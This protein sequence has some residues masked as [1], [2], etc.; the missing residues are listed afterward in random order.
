M[1]SSKKESRTKI[2][3]KF[4]EPPENMKEKKRAKAPEQ[5]TPPIQE[6]PEPVSNVL[7]GDDILALAIKKEDLK[8]QHSPRLPETE[9]KPF[10]SQK[11]IIRKP[12]PKDT[13]RKICHLVAHPA[14]PEV[15]TKPLDYSGP[16]DHFDGSDQILP[17]HILGSLEDF[18]RIAIARGNTQLA[19]LIHIPPS[20]MTLISAK[21]EP[22]QKDLK[23]EKRHPWVPPPQ[24]NFLKNW[25]RHITLRKKQQEA[26]SEHLKKPVS[27]LLMHSGDT[28]RQIQE[29]R[30]LIDRILPTQHDGKSYKDTSVFWSPLEYLGDEMTGLV[31]TKTK[32]QHGFVEPI[33]RIRKPRSIQV[34]TGLPAQKDAWYRYTWDRSLFLIYR[35][36]ELQSI[37]AELDFSQQDID[38]LEVVGRGQP[39]SSVTVED[40]TVFER[41]LESPPE[42][43]VRLDLVDNCPDSVSMPVLGPSLLFCGKPA[44]WIRGSNPQDK[45]QIGIGV[46]LTF[47]TLEGEKTSSELTVVNN[48]TVAIWYDWRRLPQLDSF[49]HLKRDRMQQFY[50]NIREGV[51]LPGETKN[52]TFFFKS[53]SAGIFR[54]CWEFKTHPTLLGGALLQVNLHAVSLAQDIFKDERKFL[55]S[56][57]ATHDAVSIAKDVLQE[58]LRGILT[59]ERMPSPVDAYLTE[60]ELFCHRN[61]HLY[62]Q[63]HVVQNL[64]QLWNQCRILSAKS[65]EARAG[66]EEHL[67]PR[68]PVTPSAHLEKESSNVDNMTN[69]RNPVREPQPSQ[70]ENEAHSNFRDYST[71]QKTRVG[72]KISQRKS[73]MEE[74][75]VEIPEVD[76]TWSL[77]ELP[78]VPLTEWNLCLKEFRKAVMKLPEDHQKEDALISLNKAALELCQEQK[79]LQ[80]NLLHQLC[81]QLWRDVIDSLVSHSLWLRILLGL[82]EKE[83][84][85]L[86]VPEEQDRKSPPITEVKTTAGKIGKETEGRKGAMQEKKQL[87]IRD[88]EDK[89][90]ARMA[91]KEDRINSKKQKAKD[92]KKI[93]KSSSRDRLSS[94]DPAPDSTV[95]SHEPI[96]PLV[97]EKYMRRMHTE[98]LELLNVLVTDLMILA[99][100]LSPIKNVEESFHL[101]S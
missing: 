64:H 50:F 101:C 21:E 23:E 69:F 35:R 17:H 16:G 29:E 26:L 55:E 47:E 18:K 79:P 45:R 1:R 87:G 48:G 58:L 32:T 4:V 52:F 3:S 53:S 66:E 61:P 89:K 36:K 72:T 83:T 98:V 85:Y 71:F 84:V 82:P 74:I 24:Q 100:E 93:L 2:P 65:E 51:I 22:Q 34:E 59:P 40:R 8:K 94:D 12:R 73:I 25:Q 78:G 37:L 90:G 42:D 11:F 63:H 14:N 39:F 54:E 76:S 81:L 33:A 6:E 60:E 97:K 5:P 56:K 31:I 44:C 30:E 27:E 91:G 57:L 75:L 86:D 46:R 20:L 19:E 41:L 10:I 28:Y 88:K 38:G 49:Q 7:Q 67:S 96:D 15:A 13:R 43:K 62:Y 77:C 99:D 92:D 68:V 9:D 80:S 70:H 95:P